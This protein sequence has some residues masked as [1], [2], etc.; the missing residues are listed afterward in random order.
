[1]TQQRGEILL[2]TGLLILSVWVFYI[3]T[4]LQGGAGRFPQVTAILIGISSAITLLRNL[5]KPAVVTDEPFAGVVWGRLF[6][7]VGAFL[8]ALLLLKPAGFPI[9]SFLLFVICASAADSA[10]FSGRTLLTN[11]LAGLFFVTLLTACFVVFLG[12][13]LPMGILPL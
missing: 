9:V 8:A 6:I 12:V 13:T 10:A 1:M 11:S 4:G 3:S 2:S 7:I 5:L